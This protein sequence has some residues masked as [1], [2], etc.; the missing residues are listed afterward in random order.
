MTHNLVLCADEKRI[1]SG[2]NVSALFHFSASMGHFGARTVSL[3]GFEW[4]SADLIQRGP[5]GAGCL[6][7]GLHCHPLATDSV[8][9]VPE[10]AAMSARFSRSGAVCGV[11]NGTGLAKSW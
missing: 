5:R 4:G 10:A 8:C 2:Q 3:R 1:E 9:R 7:N 11:T 6:G